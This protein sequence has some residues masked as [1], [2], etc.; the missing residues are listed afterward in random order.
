M[1]TDNF[2]SA[3][4]CANNMVSERLVKMETLWD[5]VEYT[6]KTLAQVVKR[7]DD[8]HAS[9]LAASKND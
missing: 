8:I 2:R 7:L 1:E 9:L 3:L 6:R 4:Q 5:L